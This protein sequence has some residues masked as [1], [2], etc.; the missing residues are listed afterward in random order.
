[1]AVLLLINSQ[2]LFGSQEFSDAGPTL[3]VY[4]KFE[5]TRPRIIICE[6]RIPPEANEP[7]VLIN[8]RV[9]SPSL[10]SEVT[11]Q[12]GAPSIL[13]DYNMQFGSNKGLLYVVFEPIRAEREAS[14]ARVSKLRGSSSNSVG[15]LSREYNVTQEVIRRK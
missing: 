6:H 9:E 3:L 14:V 11:F 8:A 1:M 7:Q 15:M 2:F 5:R 10:V 4:S 12:H 13:R